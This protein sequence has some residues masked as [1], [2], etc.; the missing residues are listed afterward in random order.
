MDKNGQIALGYKPFKLRL[1]SKNLVLTVESNRNEPR[2]LTVNPNMDHDDLVEKVDFHHRLLVDDSILEAFELPRRMDR[3]GFG[4][5]VDSNGDL[6]V[7]YVFGG[8]VKAPEQPRKSLDDYYNMMN[9]YV[10]PKGSK[11]N[12]N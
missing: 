8:K 11:L 6:N 10:T 3:Y 12:K 5:A 7:V 4:V 9:L 1:D 2:P